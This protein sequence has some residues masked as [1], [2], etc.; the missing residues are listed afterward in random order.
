MVLS[1]LA[2]NARARGI[3][4]LTG[5]YRPT[6]R[7]GLVKDHYEKLGFS[8]AGG[9]GGETRW[10]FDTATQ[11]PAPPMKV[12]RAYELAGADPVVAA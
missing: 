12:R 6:D 5:V 11:P 8:P 4:R 1:E 7:N 2:A 9:E 10:T 3:G